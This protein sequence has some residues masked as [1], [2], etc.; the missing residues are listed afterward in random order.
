MMRG[1]IFII[2]LFAS[3][4]ASATRSAL[5][6][7]PLNL[8]LRY[9]RG[10]S[11]DLEVRTSRNFALA[12]HSHSF[13]LITEYSEFRDDTGNSTSSLSRQH[14]ELL[15]WSRYNLVKGSDKSMRGVI[16]AGA[17]L[18]A[19]SESVE[20]RLMGESRTDKLQDKLMGG[21]SLG[22]ELFILGSRGFGFSVGVEGRALMGADFDPNPVLGGVLRLGLV[23]PL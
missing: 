22:L 4:H 2:I 18:G 6:I 16:Y 1:L 20:T 3:F 17:G 15:L 5:G 7:Y 12:Y 19:Y 23:A 21:A 13:T 8:D 9:E 14:Q 11:Q 10:S